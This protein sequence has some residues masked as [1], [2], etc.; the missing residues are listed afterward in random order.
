MFSDVDNAYISWV[1]DESELSKYKSMSE[2]FRLGSKDR[3]SIN[4]RTGKDY[5]K[6][7]TILHQNID[8]AEKKAEGIY[9]NANVDKTERIFENFVPL[10]DTLLNNYSSSLQQLEEITT[11]ENFWQV[12]QKNVTNLINSWIFNAI[13]LEQIVNQNNH[14]PVGTGVNGREIIHD[15]VS[16]VYTQAAEEAS[17]LVD[18]LKSGKAVLD[19]K[20]GIVARFDDAIVKFDKLQKTF[21]DEKKA[22]AN[23]L[24]T[25][26]K[27]LKR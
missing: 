11:E 2:L 1:M 6:P 21:F 5:T 18:L 9:K 14:F 3:E 22:I 27:Y 13:N 25:T 26:G 15:F 23:K 10:F 19:D 17:V 8:K 20:K 7:F 24:A 4:D 12:M 16:N